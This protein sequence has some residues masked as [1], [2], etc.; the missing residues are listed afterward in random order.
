MDVASLYDEITVTALQSPG[1]GG[2]LW[3][4]GLEEASKSVKM[5]MTATS[6][7]GRTGWVCCPLLSGIRVDEL[8][9]V[10]RT[11]L[12]KIKVKSE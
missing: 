11:S 2:W 4:E 5:T 9:I 7:D 12:D 6:S 3:V 8:G 1:E 10:L